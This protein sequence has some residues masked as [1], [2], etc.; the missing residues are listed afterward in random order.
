MKAKIVESNVATAK[1]LVLD[2]TMSSECLKNSLCSF[3]AEVNFP[4]FKKPVFGDGSRGSGRINDKGELFTWIDNEVY[5]GNGEK[6][7][8]CYK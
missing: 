4:L 3:L 8:L 2:F 1:H 6:V 7:K 5:N